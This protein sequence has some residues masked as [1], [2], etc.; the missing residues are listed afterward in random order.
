MRIST[1]K[2]S[3]D[4]LVSVIIPE[5][6]CKKTVSRKATPST[7]KLPARLYIARRTFN[8]AVTVKVKVSR[9]RPGMAQRFPGG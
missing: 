8:I 6:G 9:N 7:C 1:D 2:L 4:L 3:I 5:A